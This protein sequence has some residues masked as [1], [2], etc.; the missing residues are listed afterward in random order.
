VRKTGE[1]LNPSDELTKAHILPHSNGGDEIGYNCWPQTQATNNNTTRVEDTIV[2]GAWMERE[3]SPRTVEKGNSKDKEILEQAKNTGMAP[4]SWRIGCS[5]GW[6]GAT[7]PPPTCNFWMSDRGQ[8]STVLVVPTKKVAEAKLKHPGRS[9]MQFTQVCLHL[10]E[11]LTVIGPS[12]DGMVKEIYHGLDTRIKHV[13]SGFTVFLASLVNP[14]LGAGTDS[15]LMLDV[16]EAAYR[17]PLTL[18]FFGKSI[19]Q[20]VKDEPVLENPDYYRVGEVMRGIKRKW[21]SIS[22]RW[23]WPILRQLC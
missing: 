8:N 18:D 5:C 22:G 3:L 4:A 11:R 9:L 20:M 2:E 15:I 19:V 12:K 21:G 17:E 10:R 7:F 16:A 6:D 23:L 14:F 1:R 13:V